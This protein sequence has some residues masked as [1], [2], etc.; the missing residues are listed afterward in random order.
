MK[1]VVVNLS[2]STYEKLR[3]EA[4]LEKKD[5][6]QIIGERILDKPFNIIVEEAFD[7]YVKQGIKKIVNESF[8][9]L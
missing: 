1:K 6:G 8:N 9:D 7:F 3:F 2:D 4:I 5:I